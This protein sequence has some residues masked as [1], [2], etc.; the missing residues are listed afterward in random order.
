MEKVTVN[1]ELLFELTSMEDWKNRVPGILPRK[2][3]HGETWLWVDKNGCIFQCRAD[4]KA[5]EKQASYPC[6]VYRIKNVAD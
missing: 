1:G 4:F 3:K 6:R 5:A 2:L